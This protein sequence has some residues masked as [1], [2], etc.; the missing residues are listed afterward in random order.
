VAEITVLPT[1]EARFNEEVVSKLEHM[2]DMARSGEI[3]S[4]IAAGFKQN[5]N[6][7]MVFSGQ[8]DTLKKIGAL[9]AMKADLL[10][11]MKIET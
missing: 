4:F 10:E 2:L 11:M 1:P 8:H 3:E 9:E 7:V 5:G 6:W